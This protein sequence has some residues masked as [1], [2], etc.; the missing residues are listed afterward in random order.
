[1]YLLRRA[2]SSL[3]VTGPGS[4][5]GLQ[6]PEHMLEEQHREEQMIQEVSEKH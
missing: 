6:L 2:G 4:H 1:M 5:G 3:T